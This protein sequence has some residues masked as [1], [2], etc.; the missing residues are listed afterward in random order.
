MK[1]IPTNL[2]MSFNEQ[3]DMFFCKIF[4]YTCDLHLKLDI[5]NPLNIIVSIK[6]FKKSIFCMQPFPSKFQDFDI[7]V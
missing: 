6:W 2:K 7:F 4:S 1:K 3:P 5:L